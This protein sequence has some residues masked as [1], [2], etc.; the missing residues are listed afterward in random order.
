MI[1]ELYVKADIFEI[2]FKTNN[3]SAIRYIE[4]N[5]DKFKKVTINFKILD[6]KSDDAFV[7]EYLDNNKYKYEL[8]S[9]NKLILEFPWDK[10]SEISILPIVFRQVVELLRQRIGEIKLHAS[11]VEKNGKAILFVAPSEGGK[12]TTAMAMCQRYS[13]SFIANDASVVKII[14]N[15][16]FILRGDAEIKARLNGLKAYSQKYFDENK[17]AINDINSLWYSKVNIN[18]K[19]INIKISN[20]EYKVTHIF[21]IKLDT[22]IEKCSLIDYKL[23]RNHNEWLKPKMQLF[24]NIS[25]TIRG[26]D[27]IPYANQG[28]ILKIVIPNLDSQELYLNRIDLINNIF[29]NCHVYQLRG[30]LEKIL[31]EIN[32][33]LEDNIND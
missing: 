11:A 9:K 25:G 30:S 14:D 22:M 28:N 18:P 7:I 13:Y 15:K 21:F 16:P 26:S 29:D 32:K 2:K 12:T 23:N 4:K 8:T 27:L 20:N 19:S 33:I 17:N 3:I 1:E 10:N 5:L 31:K 6:K 24:Q